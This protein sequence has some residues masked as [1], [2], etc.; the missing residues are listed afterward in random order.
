MTG[1][2]VDAIGQRL[3]QNRRWPLEVAA[4]G[5]VFG[6]IG[7]SPLYAFDL[8]LKAATGVPLTIAVF[9]ILS[10]IVWTIMIV[11]TIKYVVFVL[12]ADNHGEG[13]IL[14]LVTRMRL[15]R[16]EK[17][18]DKILLAAGMCG[19]ALI[20]GDGMLTPAISILSAVEG[21]EIVAPSLQHFAVP[22]AIVILLLFFLLQGYGTDRIATLFGPIMLVWFGVIGTL[23]LAAI[24]KYPAVLS[25]ILP[26]HAITLLV[27]H[28]VIALAVSGA[29]F[30]AVTGAEALYADLGHFGK[31][32][33]RRAWIVVAMPALLLC[34]FGQGAHALALGR[35]PQNPMFELAAP[36]FGLPL[37]ALAT[38]AT[39]IASQ[40]ILTGAFT[41]AKQAMEIGL[42]P[43][44]RVRYTSEENERHVYVPAVNVLLMTGTMLITL[45]FGSSAAM[46]SAYGIAVSGAMATTTVL[47]IA[48]QRRSKTWNWS[49]FAAAAAVFVLVDGFFLTTN[50]LKI[51][52]GGWIPLSVA[53]AV[54]VVIWSW[55]VGHA[56]V[57][58]VQ[59]AAAET[60]GKGLAHFVERPADAPPKTMVFLTRVPAAAPIAMTRLARTVDV[61]RHPIIIAQVRI[62]SRP[63][64]QPEER[65]ALNRVDRDVWRAEIRF[66][67]MEAT[68]VPAVLQPQLERNS[69]FTAPII[70][71]VGSERVVTETASIGWRWMLMQLFAFMARNA[72]RSV[73]R[74]GLPGQNTL[75]IGQTIRL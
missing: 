56:R 59:M 1:T 13:G 41:L 12:Q 60:L 32:A 24:W 9:G 65:V 63:R 44:L 42:L 31:T 38:A 73:D 64:A 23:G 18:A 55:R 54:I 52:D 51:V 17:R 40:A 43:P 28:P 30:L 26:T 33:I 49:V 45:G 67:Y 72:V 8:A 19:A 15:H 22:A 50:L 37:L 7:T 11:V 2:V 34:Y 25:A 74:F 70:Y 21:L 46:G 29:A 20:F 68:N 71:I 14:A 5:V 39:I 48:D 16:S 35:A 62:I 47:L 58:G 75:E 61:V 6:D 66:G 57:V 27:A 4:L 36:W 53:G 69:A 3:H 10:L